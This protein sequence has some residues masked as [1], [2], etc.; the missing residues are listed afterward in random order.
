MADRRHDEVYRTFDHYDLFPDHPPDARYAK[1][2]PDGTWYVDTPKRARSDFIV[3]GRG[4]CCAV[5]VK[6][7]GD[8]E[9]RRFSF[10]QW[11]P[12]QREW[13]AEKWIKRYNN[14]FYLWLA[15]GG[16]V[17][18]KSFPAFCLLIPHD[19]YLEIEASIV[20]SGR[21]SMNYT[22]ASTFDQYKLFH[23]TGND[24]WE[25]PRKHL[26][27]TEFGGAPK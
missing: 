20:A 5:E 1:K 4:F 23:S 11:E 26:F 18:G 9:G 24:R 7:A 27:W 2:K 3:N 25:I 15:F 13:A 8:K 17:N 22:T 14:P 6:H 21:V 16:R 10:D 19:D 12:H